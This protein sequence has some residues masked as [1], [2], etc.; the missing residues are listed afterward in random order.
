[1]PYGYGGRVDASFGNR[2]IF[3]ILMLIWDAITQRES[4]ASATN[5]VATALASFAFG[6]FM[7]FEGRVLHGGMAAIFSAALIALFAAGFAVR[8]SRK[9]AELSSKPR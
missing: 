8:H 1:M 6:M 4:F 9:R 5:L 7:V 3:G 2:G